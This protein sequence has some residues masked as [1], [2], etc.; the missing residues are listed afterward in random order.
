ME[1]IDLKCVFYLSE[2]SPHSGRIQS[3]DEIYALLRTAGAR[4]QPV[5]AMYEGHPRLFCRTCWAGVSKA[6]GTRSVISLEEQVS[7]A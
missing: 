6:D 1:A 7:A 3:V 2:M 4:K 5:A